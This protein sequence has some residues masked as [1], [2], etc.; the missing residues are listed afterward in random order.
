MG[1]KKGI[2]REIAAYPTLKGERYFDGFKRSHFIVAKFHECNEVL[3]PTHNPGS[4]PEQ[5]E[6]IEAKQTFML[7]VFNANLQTDMR[8][9]IIRRQKGDSLF[10]ML[11]RCQWQ[12]QWMVDRRTQPPV[13]GARTTIQ[14]NG[15]K[16]SSWER[17]KEITDGMSV[18]STRCDAI[19]DA[20]WKKWFAGVEPLS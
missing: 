19:L 6:L 16:S 18:V 3:D 15:A 8:K 4:E 13:K 7:S 11:P 20:S 12:S 9:T 17:G 1:L 10:L 2:K 5:Q 14:F